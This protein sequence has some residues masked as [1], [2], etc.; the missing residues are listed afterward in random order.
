[1]PDRETTHRPR[2]A[3]DGTPLLGVRTGVG[4]LTAQLIDALDLT[5]ALDLIAFAVTWRGRDQLERALPPGVRS[6]TTP[7]PA[8]LAR[9][10]WMRFDIPHIERWT[11]PVDVVHA[12]NYVAPPTRAAVVLSVHDIAFITHPE[13]CAP[14]AGDYRVLIQRAIDRGAVIHTISEA[15]RTAI[16][17]VF[18]IDAS[19]VVRIYP[20]LDESPLGDATRG[21]AAA[22]VDEGSYVLALGSI[23]PRKNLPTLVR[24][25]AEIS[26][27]V[28]GTRLVVA[29]P[30]GWD[31]GAFERAVA[32]LADPGVVTR[33][34]YVSDAT[35]ANLLAGASALAYPSFDEGFG[36]PPLEAMRAGVPVVASTAGALPEVLGDAA[37][38]VGPND[39][40]ALTGALIEV[41]TD[42]TARADLVRRGHER[43][44]RYSWSTTANAFVDLYTRLAS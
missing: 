38:L 39:I 37:R 33:V 16:I 22:G 25:M 3:L 5:R 20:G 34:G 18:T 21:R 7:F 15:V 19:R 6:A 2:V 29:G 35:R 42:E 9:R 8:R 26:A 44:R 17:D 31:G 43:A 12:T 28:P 32:A 11:G 41:L 40:D 23:D 4:H 30:D 1:V 24:A 13:L 27:A 36:F 10:L 14:D